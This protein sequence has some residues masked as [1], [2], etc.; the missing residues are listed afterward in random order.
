MNSRIEE[1]KDKKSLIAQKVKVL[2]ALVSEEYMENNSEELFSGD[3][4]SISLNEG[5]IIV[6][7]GKFG[8]REA[9]AFELSKIV[10]DIN[11]EVIYFIKLAEKGAVEDDLHL[12]LFGDYLTHF[13]RLLEP[14]TKQMIKISLEN[15]R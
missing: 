2:K 9:G 5:K 6:R 15:Y 14:A 7:R 10:K 13:V 11:D 12:G 4:G 8:N 1:L 3:F